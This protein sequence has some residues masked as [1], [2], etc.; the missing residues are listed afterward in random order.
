MEGC[1]NRRRR[2]IYVGIVNGEPCL[3]RINPIY[4][5]YDSDTS[6]LEFIHEAQWCCYEMIMSLTEVYDRLYD[7]M[8]EKQLNELLDMDGRSL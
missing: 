4:F 5:D 2:N 8:S 6:D 1:T 7:K 3:Q